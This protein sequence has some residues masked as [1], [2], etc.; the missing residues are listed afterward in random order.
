M[1]AED[2]YNV[3]NSPF[4]IFSVNFEQMRLGSDQ[5]Y[6]FIE[7]TATCKYSEWSRPLWR[8][9]K[10]F[11]IGCYNLR[12]LMVENKIKEIYLSAIKSQ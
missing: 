9:A 11:L 10:S 7:T 5:N 8:C 3:R 12:A 1:G 2:N 6:K 4:A